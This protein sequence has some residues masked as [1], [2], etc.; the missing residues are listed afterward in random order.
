MKISGLSMPAMFL[1]NILVNSLISILFSICYLVK[2]LGHRL[3][4]M[5]IYKTYLGEYY[6]LIVLFSF[7][8]RIFYIHF[9]LDDPFILAMNPNP[10]GSVPGAVPSGSGGGSGNLPGGGPSGSPAGLTSVHS[11][12]FSQNESATIPPYD[13]SGSVP[14]SNRAEL[15]S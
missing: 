3:I 13:P 1:G 9:L 8:L 10:A 15:V 11:G 6:D 12:R 5:L 7:I 4:S 14:P 2:Q